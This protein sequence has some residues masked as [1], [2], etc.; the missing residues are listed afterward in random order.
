MKHLTPAAALT[1]FLLLPAAALPAQREVPY[2]YQGTVHT[3]NVRTGSLD[4]LTGVGHAVRVVQIRV[5][6]TALIASEGRSISL[7][8]LAPGAVVRAD[9]RLTDAGLLADRI[10]VKRGDP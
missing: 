10:E 3:V 1:A 5:L 8:D 4:L 6:P 2:T 9:C 7:G